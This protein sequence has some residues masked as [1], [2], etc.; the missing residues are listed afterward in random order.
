MLRV[1]LLLALLLL[2]LLVAAILPSGTL[3]AVADSE[4][5]A[6]KITQ[7]EEKWAKLSDAGALSHLLLTY[8]PIQQHK[9]SVTTS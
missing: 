3:A 7:A 9:L 5:T 1:L 8:H 6:E 2:L 4:L